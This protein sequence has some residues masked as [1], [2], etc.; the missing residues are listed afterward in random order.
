VVDQQRD[1]V[2]LAD[3]VL[4][5]G[6]DDVA[7]G[8]KPAGQRGRVRLIRRFSSGRSTPARRSRPGSITERPGPSRHP[9]AKSD[10]LPALAPNYRY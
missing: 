7:A 6:Q 9:A 1:H 3:G 2:G 4:G 8:V 10:S 5:V